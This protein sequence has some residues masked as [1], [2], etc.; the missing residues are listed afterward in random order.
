MRAEAAIT[1]MNISSSMHNAEFHHIHRV[2]MREKE[3]VEIQCSMGQ[4][5]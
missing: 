2:T 3:S 1:R 5:G 4:P